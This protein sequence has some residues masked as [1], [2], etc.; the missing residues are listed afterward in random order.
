MPSDPNE[1]QSNLDNPVEIVICRTFAAPRELLWQA[2]TDPKHVGRWWGPAGFTTTTH[3]LDFRPGG[4]WRYTMHGP[5]GRDYTNRIDYIEIEEPSRLVYQLGGDVSDVSV[6][7]RTVVSFEQVSDKQTK[8]TMRTIFPTAEARDFVINNVG[9]VEGGKQHLA[10]LE[11]YLAGLSNGVDDEL[12]FSISHVCNAPREKVWQAWTEREHLLKWFGP[13]GSKIQ[14]AT[15]DFRVGGVFHYCMSHP[16]GMEMWGRWVFRIINRPDRI[17]FISSFSNADGEVTP[18]PFQ[19]LDDFP[20]ETLTTVTLVDHAGIGKGTLVTIIARPINSTK[21][22]RDFFTA[23]H[24]S[25]RQGWA[26]T[27]QQLTEFLGD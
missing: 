12:P 14:H 15:L 17:E 7:F 4:S 21:A 22:Q 8:V 16:N 26:G 27:M 6:S 11:D 18:A 13:Q 24:S 25:M 20:P 5:D 10:N 3:A 9:A 23:F 2:W 1:S 19:G